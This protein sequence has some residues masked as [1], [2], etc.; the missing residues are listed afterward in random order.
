MKIAL[1]GAALHSCNN[2]VNALTEGTIRVLLESNVVNE[3]NLLTTVALKEQEFVDGNAVIREIPLQSKKT[4]F[5]LLI[6]M[7]TGKLF[8][9]KIV[10]WSKVY[11]YVEDSDVILDLSEGD[12]FS[13]I[14]GSKRFFLNCIGKKI[15]LKLGK[16]LIMLPQTYGPFQK[17]ITKMTAKYFFKNAQSVMARD[18]ISQSLVNDL[19]QKSKCFCF[20]DMAFYMEPETVEQF[21]KKNPT[22]GLNISGLMANGG[23]T[24]NNMFGLTCDYLSLSS[25]IIEHILEKTNFDLLLVPHVITGQ[26][27]SVENDN[28]VC[29]EIYEIYHNKYGERVR[30]FVGSSPAQIK[31][32]ISQCDLFAGGRMHACIAALST[33]VPVIPIA[34]SRKFVGVWNDLGLGEFVVDCCTNNEEACLRQF[35]L[36]LD[37]VDNSREIFSRINKFSAEEKAR[38]LEIIKN[39]V[40][41]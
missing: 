16:P 3:I 23:Y 31:F 9:Q 30:I 15:A 40:T 11:R 38:I 25:G 6:H 32:V 29:R 20:R 37:K 24:K 34:Y 21:Y 28:K 26:S 14:Y 39:G 18:S 17:S 33:G 27:D 36:L 19:L 12:S 8:T 7:L 4:A 35:I 10:K 1:F 2:G 5:V 13:D 22:I 41:L